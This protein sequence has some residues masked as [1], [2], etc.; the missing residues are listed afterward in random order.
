MTRVVRL[1]FLSVVFMLCGA[2]SDKPSEDVLK[3]AIAEKHPS[4]AVGA[5]KMES[6]EI[7]NSY[8][9]EIENEEVFFYDYAI[10]TQKNMFVPN[11][12]VTGNFS[13]VKR[14]EKWYILR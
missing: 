11:G 7:T 4:I 9:R 10:K 12:L 2:C 13:L 1:I 5:I 3:W 14:G 6:Y 8:T